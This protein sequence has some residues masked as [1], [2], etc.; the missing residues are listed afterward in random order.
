M[1]HPVGKAAHYH[2]GNYDGNHRPKETIP[3]T[4]TLVQIVCILL[5]KFIVNI[6]G[7]IPDGAHRFDYRYRFQCENGWFWPRGRYRRLAPYLLVSRLLFPQ[8]RGDVSRDKNTLSTYLP[9]I[10]YII[11]KTWKNIILF[12]DS[13]LKYNNTPLEYYVWLSE[14]SSQFD[15]DGT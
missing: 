1:R 3:I 4:S 6:H 14:V 12:I 15:I 2:K 5:V 8:L 7:A 13:N 9:R 10:Q 11:R